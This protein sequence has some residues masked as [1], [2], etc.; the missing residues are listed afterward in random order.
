MHTPT[1]IASVLLFLPSISLAS[2]ATVHVRGKLMCNGK[3]YVD[4]E[5]SLYEKNW[6]GR[7]TKLVATK[8]DANGNFV[9]KS[10]MSEWPLFT[11]NPYIYFGNYCDINNDLGSLQCADGIKI[12]IPDYF[13]HEGN[14][15]KSTFDIGEL[16]MMGMSPE[17]LG[18]AKLV[19]T[20]FTQQDCRD[21][22]RK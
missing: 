14:L 15:P 19:Y 13:V 5:I 6:V 4:G 22:T 10:S 16:E 12:F 8:T 9:L 3:P 17:N 18:L 11:P 2:D 20:I 7:D 21:V 1:L